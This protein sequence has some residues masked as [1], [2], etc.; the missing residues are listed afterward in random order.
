LFAILLS[1][2][3]PDNRVHNLKGERASRAEHLIINF[4]PVQGYFDHNIVMSTALNTKYVAVIPTNVSVLVIL[5]FFLPTFSS[6]VKWIDV[7]FK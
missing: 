7:L 2:S 3:P 1:S 4:T 5:G 6:Y